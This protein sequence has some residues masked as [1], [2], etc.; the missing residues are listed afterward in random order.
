MNLLHLILPLIRITP[1]HPLISV[2]LCRSARSGSGT[3]FHPS[4]PHGALMLMTVPMTM[5]LLTMM[6][7]HLAHPLSLSSTLAVPVSWSGL[8]RGRHPPYRSDHADPA[9]TPTTASTP[10]RETGAVLERKNNYCNLTFR[11]K[12][13]IQMKRILSFE[14]VT[15]LLARI[16]QVKSQENKKNAF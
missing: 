4:V 6:L 2:A 9:R 7:T 5:V 15:H 16:C 3:P 14:T 8:D 13:Q 1:L 11:M 12:R 10:V